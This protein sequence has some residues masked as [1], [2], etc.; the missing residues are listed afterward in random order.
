MSGL[1]S[2]ISTHIA[3]NY[4]HPNG[5]WGI[6]DPLYWRAVGS[7]PDRLNNMYFAFLFLLRSVVRAQDTL[8]A[9][10][11]DTGHAYD[12]QAVV[13]LLDRLLASSSRFPTA[14]TGGFS[15]IGK[16]MGDLDELQEISARAAASANI[17]DDATA[18]TNDNI[19]SS[20]A[21][22]VAMQAVEECR[23]GFNESELFQVSAAQFCT[24]YSFVF[25]FAVL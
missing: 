10:P 11:Y 3:R 20:T 25:F 24:T 6:N 12:D 22:E 21:E 19:T 23:Y 15:S 14:T 9:Y 17:N 16:M 8:R 7:H 18:A 13:E 1:Q 2:S 5:Q 4:L